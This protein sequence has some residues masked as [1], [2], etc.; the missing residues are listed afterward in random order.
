[1]IGLPSL[2]YNFWE[3]ELVGWVDA[4]FRRD[5]VDLTLRAIAGNRDKDGQVHQ[6]RWA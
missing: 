6:I 1:M 3:G 4:L 5:G 2:G